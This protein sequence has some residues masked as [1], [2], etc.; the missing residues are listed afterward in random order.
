MA[1]CSKCGQEIDD[2]AAFCPACGAAVEL[3]GAHLFC[4]NRRCRPQVIARLSHFASRDAMDI[5]T[6]SD[7]S[8][9][10]LQ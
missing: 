8:D 9:G 7:K 4:P 1:Y 6:L 5:E 10:D 2:K 3:R